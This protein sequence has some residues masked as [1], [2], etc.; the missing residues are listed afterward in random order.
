MRASSPVARSR[1]LSGADDAPALLR[2]AAKKLS[3][4]EKR[5]LQKKVHARA[6]QRARPL[7]ARTQTAREQRKAAKRQTAPETR[8]AEAAARAELELLAMPTSA[9]VRA[10]FADGS[11]FE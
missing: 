10:V 11:R 2:S 9:K 4:R 1:S 7:T 8:A 3:R 6:R 5:K